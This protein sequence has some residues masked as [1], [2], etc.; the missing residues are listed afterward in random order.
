VV[1]KEKN[2]KDPPS[3]D[4]FTAYIRNS[5]PSSPNKL[6]QMILLP[7]SK[8]AYVM[9]IKQAL[10]HVMRIAMIMRRMKIVC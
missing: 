6:R 5:T 1:K 7:F 10:T 9:L 8:E 3:E 4:L 2:L